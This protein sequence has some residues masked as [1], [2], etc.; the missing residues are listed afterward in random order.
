[1]RKLKLIGVSHQNIFVSEMWNA[2][3]SQQNES[4]CATYSS[5]SKKDSFNK[6]GYEQR[7]KQRPRSF[8]Q[9]E[10]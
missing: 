4:F 1:M 8:P 2:Q 3:R 5:K 6:V 7:K 10:E 9:K